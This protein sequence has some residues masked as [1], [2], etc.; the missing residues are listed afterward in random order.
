[1]NIKSIT[2]NK[3]KLKNSDEIIIILKDLKIDFI[4]LAG[5]LLLLPKKI[6]KAFPNRIVNIHPA[7]LPKYGGNGMYGMNVHKSVIENHEKETGITIHYVNDKYDE[8]AII[9]QAK[10]K[11]ETNDTPEIIAEKIHLLE[12]EFYPYIIEKII[13]EL[14]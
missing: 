4:V 3:E 6:L 13:N 14:K 12:Y 11:I 10:C 8:G 5:F 9:Y 2:F 1:L 7:L